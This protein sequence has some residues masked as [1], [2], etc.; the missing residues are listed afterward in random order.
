MSRAEGEHYEF[1]KKVS[2]VDAQP[3]M[4]KVRF[5]FLLART[6]GLTFAL[7]NGPLV[8]VSGIVT[9]I[10]AAV[11]KDLDFRQRFLKMAGISLGVSAF[12]FLVGLA[13][14][15]LFGIEI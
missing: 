5:F 14:R 1:W 2:G 13:V 10:A 3:R 4:G 12:S 8:A 9:G 11:A 6:L 7:R 15:A